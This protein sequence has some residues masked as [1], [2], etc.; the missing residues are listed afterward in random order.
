MI[1]QS[2]LEDCDALHY[3]EVSRGLLRRCCTRT[4]LSASFTCATSICLRM[5]S[6]SARFCWIPASFS[7][8][9]CCVSFHWFMLLSHARRIL[10]RLSQTIAGTFDGSLRA[11]RTSRSYA[12]ASFNPLENG[13]VGSHSSGESISWGESSSSSLTKGFD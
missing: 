2:H 9:C 12:S 13:F 7:A 1:V 3:G 10:S 4:S 6:F 11:S 5:V 8:S